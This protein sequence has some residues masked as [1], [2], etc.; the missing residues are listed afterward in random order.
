MIDETHQGFDSA[1]LKR[2]QASIEKD[3]K[4]G[5]YDGANLVIS[6]GGKVAMDVSLGF[7]H[8]ESQRKS[9]PEDVY[10]LFSLTKAFTHTLVLQ[11]IERGQM[12]FMDRVV[13][14]I[15]E[16]IGKDRFRQAKKE[17][18]NI[19]HLLSHRAGLVTTPTPLPYE[20][21][22]NLSNVI[23]AICELDVVGTPG[24]EVEYSPTLNHA[25]MGE[26]VRRATGA[27]SFTELVNREI[28]GPL[29][30]TSTRMGAPNE[31]KDRMVPIVANFKPGGWFTARDLEVMQE[32]VIEGAEMPW[33][34]AVSTARDISRFSEMLRN[35]GTF[36]GHRILSPAM[37]D[38]A[39]TLQTGISP[40]NLYARISIMN[41]WQIP[42]AN[43]G[44]GYALSGTGTHPTFFGSLTSPRT[45]GN[46]GAGSTLFWVDPERDITFSCLTSGLLEEANNV[47]RFAKLSD[48]AIAAAN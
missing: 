7:A 9:T 25:L 16:F 39:T 42:P 41:N 23:K 35:K 22:G 2:L 34:G 32:I 30:M 6:R 26:M 13:D 19:V 29:G 47:K 36:E 33:V 10:W 4:D 48:M 1:A 21:L 17:Q 5:L 12:S 28:F 8:R 27:K 43:L 3:V 45:F 11:A 40:N 38:L 44:L 46:Y 37:V 14:W 24:G 15:P 31:F 18:I 20:E